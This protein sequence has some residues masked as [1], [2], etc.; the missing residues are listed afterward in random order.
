MKSVLFSDPTLRDGNHAVSHQLSAEQI[1]AYCRAADAARVDIVEVG[2][3][4]GLGAS[5]LHIG[6]SRCPDEVMLR[7]A[8]DALSTSKLGVH[9]IP[10]YA[11]VERDVRRAIEI[12]VDVVRVASHCTEADLCERHIAFVRER[13]R[14]AYGVLMMSHMAR[15]GAA[16]RGGRARWSPTARRGS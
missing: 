11:T 7:T 15:D 16:R 5:S 12:G 8:R 9:V 3:G 13:G 14:T 6:E 1:A 2:H 10:G 4:N